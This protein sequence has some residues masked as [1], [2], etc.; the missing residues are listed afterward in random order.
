MGKL[1]LRPRVG[2]LGGRELPCRV[3]LSRT[4]CCPTLVQTKILGLAGAVCLRWTLRPRTQFWPMA[5]APSMRSG[6][7]LQ[8]QPCDL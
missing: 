4:A 6:S 5:E 2:H 3:T 1:G 7:P 8:G